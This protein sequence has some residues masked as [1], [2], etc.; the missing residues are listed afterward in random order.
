MTELRFRP[1]ELV[2]G[3]VGYVAE[4]PEPVGWLELVEVFTGETPWKT[5]EATIYDLVSF[6]A[7]TRIGHAGTRRRADTRAVKLTILG[8]AW[9]DQELLELP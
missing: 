4:A 6:G 5:V 2:L 8:R 7:I 1:A 9:L 3:I